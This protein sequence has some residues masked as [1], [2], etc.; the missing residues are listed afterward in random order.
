MDEN[1]RA[2]RDR[3]QQDFPGYVRQT[4][5]DFA[6]C[7]KCGY[8]ADCDAFDVLGLDDGQLWCN[9]CDNE[10]TPVWL[11]KKPERKADEKTE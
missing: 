7:P 3:L 9:Q 5:G 4:A 2:R 10:I 8:V 1:E 11:D 6:G